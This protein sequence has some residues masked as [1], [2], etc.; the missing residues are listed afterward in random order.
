MRFRV[1]QRF[2]AALAQVEAALLDPA[3]L[4]RL[5]DLP[6]LGSPELLGHD[7][8]GDLVRMRVRYRFTGALSPA[9]TAV[10]DPDRL[11]WVEETA[12]DRRAHRGEHTIVPD[13]YAGRLSSSY[14]TQLEMAAGVTLRVA[15]G[16]L[17]VRFPLVAGR[18]ERAIV[19]GLHTHAERE[20]EALARWLEEQ[21]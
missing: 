20:G 3:F 4:A 12:Y 9:V 17:R 8:D 21:G 2:A 16:E 5:A 19:A 14:V 18:V 11:T 15:D 10:V 7:G 1:E 6:D 13:H